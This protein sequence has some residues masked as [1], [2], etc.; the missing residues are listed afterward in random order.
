MYKRQ[1]VEQRA[2]N[3]SEIA[4]KTEQREINSETIAKEQR[5]LEQDKT[6]R[7]VLIK[8]IKGEVQGE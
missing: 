6:I 5:G 2:E 1:K 4:A 3:K 7:D 8:E